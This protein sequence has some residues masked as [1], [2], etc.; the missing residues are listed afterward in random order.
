MT[1][2]DIYS[3]DFGPMSALVAYNEANKGVRVTLTTGPREFARAD[4]F[5]G[6][7]HYH[8]NH[9]L[10]PNPLATVRK[11]EGITTPP[12]LLEHLLEGKGLREWAI[13]AEELKVAEY[14]TPANVAEVNRFIFSASYLLW[15]KM[16]QNGFEEHH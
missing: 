9:Y 2:N 15:G 8:I 3:A 16:Y 14:L 1:S 11:V 13:E 4:A 5:P 10:D 12:A 6:N 7:F